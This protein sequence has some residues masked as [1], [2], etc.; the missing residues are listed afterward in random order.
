MICHMRELRNCIDTAYKQRSPRKE[1]PGVTIGILLTA[2]LKEPH[3]NQKN[4]E[5]GDNPT[6]K[7]KQDKRNA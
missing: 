1:E 2:T 6:T 3:V 5:Y 7:K 4:Q